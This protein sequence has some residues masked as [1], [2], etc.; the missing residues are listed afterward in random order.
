[1]AKWDIA[2]EGLTCRMRGCGIG[3]GE[4]YR[5]PKAGLGAICEDCSVALDGEAQPDVVEPRSFL[6]RIRDEIVQAP[7]KAT[8]PSPVVRP[9]SQPAFDPRGQQCNRHGVRDAIRA[10]ADEPRRLTA[11][12][13]TLRRGRARTAI[14]TPPLDV[15]RRAAG[16][17]DE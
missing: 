14:V 1:M 6:D 13:T 12:T 17:R 10:Y 4:A 2:R 8:P 11:P 7:P 9:G 15:W 16:E 3:Q 5:V